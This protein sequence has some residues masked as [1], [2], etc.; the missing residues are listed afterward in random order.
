M[1]EIADRETPS[2]LGT[3]SYKGSSPIIDPLETCVSCPLDERKMLLKYN[4]PGVD[5][6]P[7]KMSGYFK[8]ERKTDR[9]S[10]DNNA[11][12]SVTI[13]TLADYVIDFVSSI[14]FTVCFLNNNQISYDVL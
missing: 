6:D 9:Q 8:H 2:R 5:I 1:R 13:S 14:L 4:T 7:G 3:Q 12:R 11:Q 10:S